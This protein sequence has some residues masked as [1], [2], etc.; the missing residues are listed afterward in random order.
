MLK[1]SLTGNVIEGNQ[2]FVGQ[3]FLPLLNSFDKVALCVLPYNEDEKK[4]VADIS[5]FT[6]SKK[7][8]TQNKTQALTTKFRLPT[9]ILDSSSKD[10][11]FE[12]LKMKIKANNGTF[13]LA[14]NHGSQSY[15]LSETIESQFLNLP[16]SLLMLFKLNPEG[17]NKSEILGVYYHHDPKSA[18][19]LPLNWNDQSFLFLIKENS[20]PDFINGSSQ[21][22]KTFIQLHKDDNYDYDSDYSYMEE[23]FL[24]LQ[25]NGV[26]FG[27]VSFTN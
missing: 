8:P 20:E 7:T 22:S 4:I 14:L 21:E 1:E 6:K 3:V 17:S 13:N 25:Y 12:H 19:S 9:N 11:L 24:E 10:I 5:T 18:R 16:Q 27:E 23:K 15:G 26:T 2:N